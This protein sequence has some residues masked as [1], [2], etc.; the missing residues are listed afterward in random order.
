M[1]TNFFEIFLFKK[2][3]RLCLYNFFFVFV[4]LFTVP[5]Q[6]SGFFDDE[7]LRIYTLLN[8]LHHDAFLARL[9]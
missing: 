1:I 6:L 5:T 8:K 7:L 9:S 4:M 3:R 2:V